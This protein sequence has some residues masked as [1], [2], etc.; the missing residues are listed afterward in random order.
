MAGTQM[1]TTPE[2]VA[3]DVERMVRRLRGCSRWRLEV[4]QEARGVSIGATWENGSIL[5]PDA[6]NP[7]IVSLRQDL[8]DERGISAELG[9]E[10]QVAE[11][12]LT[13]EQTAHAAT[14]AQLD[15]LMGIEAPAR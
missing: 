12:A 7:L 5:E 1:T 9:R 6:E 2:A 10:L 11:D 3:G 15:A 14:R 4:F 8:A 13:Q